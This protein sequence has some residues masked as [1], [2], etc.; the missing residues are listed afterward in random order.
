MFT[1]EDGEYA[2]KLA[3]KAIECAVKD[4]KLSFK[5]TPEKFE[6]EMGA[7]VTINKHPSEDLRGCIGYPE[8]TYPLKEAIIRGA[9]SATRDPRFSPLRED[10]LDSVIV[11]VSLLTPPEKLD[12]EE[13]KELPEKITCGKNGLIV[14]KGTRRGLLLPQ[15]SVDQDWDEEQFLDHTCR[16]AGLPHNEWKKGDCKIEVFEG[17]IFKEEEPYGD[18][19]K[20]DIDDN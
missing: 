15:V 8:P 1:Q 17:V 11:E 5:K 10:E 16:K 19:V 6:K 4:E 12:Y 20:R 3:R 13:P 9:Q 7:F 18:V 2:V 14:S